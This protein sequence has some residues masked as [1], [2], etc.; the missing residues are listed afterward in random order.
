MGTNIGNSVTM[1]HLLYADDTLIFCEPITSQLLYLN[2]TLLLFEALSGLHIN[3]SKSVMYP[4][5]DVP[6]LEES[7]NIMG[8]T[9]GSF[10]TTY[11]GLPLGAKYK[12]TKIWNGIIGKFEKRLA[13]WQMHY[14]SM[15]GRLTL[16]NS[17]LDSIPTY[18]LSLFP[19]PSKVLKKLDKIRRDFLWEGNSTSRKYH[20]V[21][22][23]KVTQSKSNGGLGIRDLALHNKSLL[24]KWLWRFGADESSL[25]KE[26]IVTK[27]GRRDNW[28]TNTSTSSHEVGPWQH[29]SKLG[30][31]FFE[32]VSF[33][34]GNGVNISF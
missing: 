14:L 27:H 4:V 25:W 16:I 28:R 15:G 8:C 18:Y 23:S 24:M 9:I 26:V 7:F 2:L 22:W 5:N 13:A 19:I 31:K 34:A 17:V 32:Q 3:M 29:I 21:K 11:L 1:S 6:N 10:P 12:N 33:R 30:N 20:L